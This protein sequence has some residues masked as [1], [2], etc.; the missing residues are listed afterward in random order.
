MLKIKGITLIIT[1]ELSKRQREFA[2]ALSATEVINPVDINTITQ[3]RALTG[4]AGT[5]IIFE[6]SGAQARLDTTVASLRVRRTIVVVSLWEHKPTIYTFAI[7]FQEKNVIGAALYDNRDFKA[8]IDEIASGILYQYSI[9]YLYF[10]IRYIS[11]D[12]LLL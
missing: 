12:L 10:L 3:V 5:D 11:T 7:I 6:C 9:C 2:L 8:V 4:N 1:V